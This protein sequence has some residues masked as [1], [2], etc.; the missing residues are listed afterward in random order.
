MFLSSASFAL[1]PPSNLSAQAN[2]N[3]N[4]VILSW[5]SV[6]GAAGYNVYRKELTDLEY[7]RINFG[8]VKNAIFEDKNVQKG[9]DYLYM[10]RAVDTFNTESPDS[11][12]VGAPLM[13]I[14]TIAQVTTLRDEP[15]AAKSI[16]TGKTVTFAAP[17]DVITY[18]ITYA[19]LGYSSATGIRI[20]YAIPDGT[21]IAGTPVVKKGPPIK[22]TYFDRAQNKWLSKR[23]KDENITKVRFMV[24]GTVAPIKDKSDTSGQIDLNVLIAL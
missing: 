24:D 19:N 15:L 18:S 3:D 14:N 11:L 5:D 2:P 13:A 12:A 7:Q 6:P 8:V 21:I 1:N 10:V 23:E 16:K 4:A 17:G 9:K 20:D 22:V